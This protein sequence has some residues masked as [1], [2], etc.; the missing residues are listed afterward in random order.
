MWFRVLE[1]RARVRESV[2]WVAVIEWFS[3]GLTPATLTV[4]IS[5]SVSQAIYLP[6]PTQE[7]LGSSLQV[8][9]SDYYGT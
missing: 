1:T 4:S 8:N 9:I 6:S 7:Y 2:L 3:F 5:L